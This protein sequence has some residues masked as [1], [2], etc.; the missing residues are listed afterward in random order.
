MLKPGKAE[1]YENM[2][3]RLKNM[4]QQTKSDTDSCR[5]ISNKSDET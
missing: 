2:K 4:D 3:D 5:S 1:L